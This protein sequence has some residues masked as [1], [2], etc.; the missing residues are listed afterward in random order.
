MSY[1]A[2][3]RETMKADEFLTHQDCTR[4]ILATE[5]SHFVVAKSLSTLITG[6]KKDES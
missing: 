5:N 2:I 6:V 4:F 3:N 1:W